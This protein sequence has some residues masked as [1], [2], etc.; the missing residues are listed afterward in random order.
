[1]DTK[2]IKKLLN[3]IVIKGQ[4]KKSFWRKSKE[5]ELQVY[6]TPVKSK[7]IFLDI[8]GIDIDHP[9]LYLT[10]NTGDNISSVYDWVLKNDH[11]I[12]FERNRI[13]N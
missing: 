6:F 5:F 8:N 11:K 13:Q 7:I 12:I 4:T 9:K 10:F 2:K 3:L 1:M